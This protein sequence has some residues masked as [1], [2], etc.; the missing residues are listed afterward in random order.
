M[1]ALPQ[2]IPV[3]AFNFG[4]GGT[5]WPALT[6]L[7]VWALV[8]TLIASFLGVLL[9]SARSTRAA[10]QREFPSWPRHAPQLDLPA[11]ST[12]TTERAANAAPSLAMLSAHALE[13]GVPSTAG[14]YRRVKP[15]KAAQG[16]AANGAGGGNSQVLVL[17]ER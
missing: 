4:F 7:L 13:P 15:R 8:V 12:H 17:G 16:E 6:S 1:F 14:A 10:S 2:M 5:D 11:R 9:S 3:P